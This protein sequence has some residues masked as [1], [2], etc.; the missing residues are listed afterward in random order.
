MRGPHTLV[1][2]LLFAAAGYL[3]AQG[4]TPSVE[5]WPELNFYLQQGETFR[6]RVQDLAISNPITHA[7]NGY[8]TVFVEAA[9]K[10]VFRQDLRNHEDVYRRRYLTFGAAYR[11]K[12]ALTPG[13]AESEN[14]AIVDLT[15]RYLLPWQILLADRNRGEFRFIK[16]S[17]FSTR[18]R[19]L[20]RME[21]DLKRGSFVCTPYA[22]YEIFYDTR[23]D[24]WT[25]NRY[26][27]GIQ[28]PVGP[29]VEW[30]PYYMRQNG[31]RSNPPRVN[32]FGLKLNLFF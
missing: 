4:H 29:H 1:A 19:N 13:G 12:S 21:R 31:S 30:E 3:P 18:Y 6:A 2:W 17:G 26:A 11:Y 23:Y 27:F 14:R 22:Y 9:L 16:G 5:Y 24:L 15:S 10:P 32:A 28:L 20:L 7:W 25:P 8:F